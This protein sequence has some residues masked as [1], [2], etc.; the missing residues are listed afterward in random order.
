MKKP[1]KKD[2]NR[3][4]SGMKPNRMT[5]IL[6]CVAAVLLVLVIGMICLIPEE[7]EIPVETNPPTSENISTETVEMTELDTTPRETHPFEA[8]PTETAPPEMLENMAEYYEKNN[9]FAAWITIGDTK[10]DYPVMHTP[11]FPLKY[12][13]M[14]FDGKYK[15][16]GSLFVDYTCSF[17]PESQVILIHGH[18]MNDGSMFNNLLNYKS[19]AYWEKRPTITFSTL[20]EER[21]Y[22]I[23][24]AF[25]D[26]IYDESE[27]VFRYY[28]F[29]DPQTEAEFNEGIAYFK[30]KTTYDMGVDVEYG[31]KL[32]MLST[33]DRTITDGRFVVVARLVTE[34][35]QAEPPVETQ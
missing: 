24:A 33:C 10:I 12:L 16:R 1:E 22:E 17:E 14:D 29:I 32:L 3:F 8:I 28:E 23:F 11:Y 9:D 18:N 34:D 6:S 2:N 35:D 5:V 26:K 25:R 31:D 4:S 27:D 30:E 13:Y 21:T 7:Q 19:Q 15:Y 20:Y